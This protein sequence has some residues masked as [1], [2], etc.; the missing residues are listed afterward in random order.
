MLPNCVLSLQYSSLNADVGRLASALVDKIYAHIEAAESANDFQSL[1][2]AAPSF[3]NPD[4]SISDNPTVF[5]FG[6]PSDSV[7][8]PA[9]ALDG[10]NSG[11]SNNYNNS[12]T[13]TAVVSSSSS[14]S[15]SGSGQQPV[16]SSGGVGRGSHLTTP[17][18]MLSS[19]G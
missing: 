16:R 18:W 3:N 5:Y 1:A 19:N 11:S 8:F 14:S 9:A 10:S 17:A 6:A 15:G 7:Q 2:A 13:T 12:P 4:A